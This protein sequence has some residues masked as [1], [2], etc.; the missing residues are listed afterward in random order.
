MGLRRRLNSCAP[1]VV[2]RKP[3]GVRWPSALVELNFCSLNSQH[4]NEVRQT[5]L[6]DLLIWNPTRT[7][8]E[9]AP[10]RLLYEFFG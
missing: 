8:I 7:R 4:R 3:P 2:D 5:A 10:T 6:P 9:D 1:V